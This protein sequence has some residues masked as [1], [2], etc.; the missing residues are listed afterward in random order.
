MSGLFPKGRFKLAFDPFSTQ[1]RV[2]GNS[3]D[4]LKFTFYALELRRERKLNKTLEH[5]VAKYSKQQ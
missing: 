2:S 5:M 4:Y 3:G 1:S